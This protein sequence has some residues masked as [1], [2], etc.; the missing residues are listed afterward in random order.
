MADP[1]TTYRRLGK[2]T[3]P[4]MPTLVAALLVAGCAVTPDPLTS[5]QLKLQGRN[6]IET[7]FIETE[8]LPE[9]LTL[10]EAIARAL[11]YNLDHRVKMA[12]EALALGRLGIDRLDFLPKSKS[13]ADYRSRSRPYGRSRSDTGTKDP[14]DSYYYLEKQTT[15]TDLVLSWNILDFGISY[16]TAKQNTDHAL[17]ATERRRKAIHDLIRDVRSAYWRVAASQVLEDPIRDTLELAQNELANVDT[18]LRENL[19]EPLDAN[20][21]KKMLL[22]NIWELESI[23]QELS[24]AHIDLALLINEKPGTIIR[25]VVPEEGVLQPPKWDT[26]M[27]EMERLAFLNNPDIREG[28][29]ESRI[30]I[31]E[32]HKAIVRTLPGIELASSYRYDSDDSLKSNDWHEWSTGLTWNVFN[33]LSA[34]KRIEYAELA[35]QVAEMQRLALRMAVLAQ[36]HVVDRQFRDAL[37][38]FQL[39]DSLSQVNR[40]IAELVKIRLAGDRSIRDFVYEQTDAITSQLQRYETYADLEAAYGRIHAT[41]GLDIA[42]KSMGAFDD[43]QEIT[44]AVDDTLLA[45]KSGDLIR[46]ALASEKEKERTLT[47]QGEEAL[48]ENAYFMPATEMNAEITR[49]SLKQTRALEDSDDDRDGPAW[50][51]WKGYKISTSV[52]R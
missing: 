44:I 38:Q 3:R 45:W 25:V 34:P 4:I 21:Y 17:I 32:T 39:A 7:L 18:Q 31:Q 8:P 5:E 42:P 46:N 24:T 33:I 27:D 16:F 26:S 20:H 13:R 49:I 35:E 11:K 28:F 40:R 2:L 41:L 19:K 9:I 37:K 51:N 12:E 43:L 6:D 47:E 48:T 30:A 36:V 29:Y 52:S 50:D 14:G 15:S 23:E 10:S 22:E 1:V